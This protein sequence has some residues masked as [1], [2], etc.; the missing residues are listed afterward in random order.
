MFAILCAYM[1][2]DSLRGKPDEMG[3][4]PSYPDGDS[5]I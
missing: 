2:W 3:S 1:I 5:K 4:A